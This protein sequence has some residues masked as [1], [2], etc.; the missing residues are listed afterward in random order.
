MLEKQLIKHEGLV[1][2]CY[3]CQAGKL[4]IGV[5]RN[6]EGKGI[7]PN[8]SLH[9]FGE[10]LSKP[11]YIERFKSEGI[12]KENAMFLLR[13]DIE[14]CKYH[15]E[16]NPFYNIQSQVRK[17]ALINMCFNMGYGKLKTF[18][19]MIHYLEKMDFEKAGYEMEDSKWFKQVGRRSRNL[20]YQMWSNEYSKI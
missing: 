16:K 12:S 6:L 7:T 3:H 5:G 18:K 10:I 4:T 8:E 19:K 17:D 1:L 15:L 9:I 13:N 14:D 2:N 11:Q 20:Q